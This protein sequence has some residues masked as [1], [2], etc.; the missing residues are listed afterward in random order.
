MKTIQALEQELI[1]ERLQRLLKKRASVQEG[2]DLESDAARKFAY[3]TELDE[4]DVQIK[5][6][7]LQLGASDKK[8]SSAAPGVWADFFQAHGVRDDLQPSITVNCNREEHYY[9]GLHKHFSETFRANSNRL[10]CIVACPYQRPS[11]IAKR[12]VYEVRKKQ[13]QIA[14]FYDDN[15]PDEVAVA[16]LEFGFDPEHTWNLFWA[17]I[18]TRIAGNTFLPTDSLLALADHCGDKK[19]IALLFRISTRHWTASSLEHLKYLVSKFENMPEGNRK[20]LVFFT[21]EFRYIHSA[22]LP[23]YQNVL[24]QI[25]DLCQTANSKSLFAE[26]YNLLP[27]V[28]SESIQDWSIDILQKEKEAGFKRLLQQLK[29][30]VVEEDPNHPDSF[31]MELVETMQEAAWE[32]RNRPDRPDLPF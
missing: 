31:S 15:R 19:F 24:Q 17:E 20:Y 10:Y 22:N 29:D 27:P 3:Q 4:L 18:K 2:Y 5:S 21:L 23:T 30:Q 13:Q 25:K 12:L 7:K 26:C 1:E 8:S 9:N 14:C 11:S 28:K 6:L 16:D 32:H